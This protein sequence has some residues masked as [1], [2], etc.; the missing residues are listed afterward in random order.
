MTVRTLEKEQAAEGSKQG[1]EG[2]VEKVLTVAVGLLRAASM[3][4][5]SF[6]F[7]HFL[8]PAH[9]Y[10]ISSSG[11]ACKLKYLVNL[12]SNYPSNLNR[13]Y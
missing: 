5:R 9:S 4:G 3:P 13:K 7:V 2:E 12:I 8:Y 6:Y 1:R 11:K 10:H